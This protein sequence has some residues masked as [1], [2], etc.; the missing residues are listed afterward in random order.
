MN[1]HP[2]AAA[3]IRA[4]GMPQFEADV[5]QVNGM[6]QLTRRLIEKGETRR[7]G[8]T[9]DVSVQDATFRQ[10]ALEAR[11]RGTQGTYYTRIRFFP[12]PGHFCECP[13]W[14]QNG[15]RIGPCKH[16][17]RLAEVWEDELI[18]KLERM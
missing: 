14:Q 18:G 2:V 10:G 8:R 4:G 12:R 17:L 11:M 15:P 9:S 13:D 5:A 7:L 6:I 1:P 16:V 3:Y